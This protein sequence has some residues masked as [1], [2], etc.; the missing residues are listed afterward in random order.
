MEELQQMNI[1]LLVQSHNRCDVRG[2]KRRVTPSY[3]VLEIR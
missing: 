1:P 2:A 3:Y